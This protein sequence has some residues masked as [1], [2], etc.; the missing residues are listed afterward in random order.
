MKYHATM[1]KNKGVVYVNIRDSAHGI[2]LSVWV[3]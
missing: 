1:K 3:G 2:S